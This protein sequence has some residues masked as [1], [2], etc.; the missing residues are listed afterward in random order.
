MSQD[1][2][3]G[4]N[5]APSLPRPERR[6]QLLECAIQVFARRGIGAARHAEIAAEAG[7]AVPTVFSY[8]PT[9]ANLV[10]SVVREVDRF[11]IDMIETVVARESSAASTMLGIVRAFADRGDSHPDFITVWL[12]WS[13]SIRSEVWPLYRDF[14]E[15]VVESF[16]RVVQ[17]G[18]ESG[19]LSSELDPEAAAHLVVGS[20]NMIAQMKL[21]GRDPERVQRFL[22]TVINGA[23]HAN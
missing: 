21:T 5:R 11:L 10:E 17:K 14:Q 7:V 19:E 20:G 13:T 1:I 22:E 12:D 6:S 23:L 2:I 18:Q 4:K 3:G 8:F 9:R 16:A 15:R